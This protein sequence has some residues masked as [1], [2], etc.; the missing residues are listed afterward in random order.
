M[1][2]VLGGKAGSN[3]SAHLVSRRVRNFVRK[4]QRGPNRT[5]HVCFVGRTRPVGPVREIHK[6]NDR[7][8]KRK[9]SRNTKIALK[10]YVFIQINSHIVSTQAILHCSCVILFEKIPVDVKEKMIE[11][12]S[13]TLAPPQSPPQSDP[14]NSL[15]G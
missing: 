1:R 14:S 15:Y 10:N 5:G 7:H 8:K 6:R 13:P 9:V 12:S 3:G 2:T 4:K 11:G